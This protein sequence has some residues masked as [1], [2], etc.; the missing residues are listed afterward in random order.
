L[1]TYIEN[2]RNIF[3][4]FLEQG[5]KCV[6]NNFFLRKFKIEKINRF[7]GEQET[8]EEVLKDFEDKK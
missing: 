5:K 2:I 1:D 4:F 8:D 3:D 7:F 6:K